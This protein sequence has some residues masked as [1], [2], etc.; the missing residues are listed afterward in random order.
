VIV[1][2]GVARGEPG[3]GLGNK[4]RRVRWE[5]A[6]L[7]DLLDDNAAIGVALALTPA[8]SANRS[9]KVIAPGEELRRVQFRWCPTL[10][11]ALS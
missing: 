2:G 4:D 9:A 11:N 10:G 6:G 5:A 7:D 8:P 3:A 1:R